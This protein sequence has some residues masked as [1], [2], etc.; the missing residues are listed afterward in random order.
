LLQTI[1][2][3]HGVIV[4]YKDASIVESKLDKLGYHKKAAGKAP[5]LAVWNWSAAVDA[6]TSSALTVDR[7]K[8]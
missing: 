5:D 4:S 1:S 7:P 2:R 3:K 6:I 8:K